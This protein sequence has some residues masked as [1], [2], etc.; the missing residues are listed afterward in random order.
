MYLIIICYDSINLLSLLYCKKIEINFVK[1]FNLFTSNNIIEF[2][3]L[4]IYFIFSN[5]YDGK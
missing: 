4:M 1:S 2:F 5:L 3:V